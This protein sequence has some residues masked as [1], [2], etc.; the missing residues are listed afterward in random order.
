[1]SSPSNDINAPKAKG[2]S[3]RKVWFGASAIVLL[4][5]VLIIGKFSGLIEPLELAQAV[6][7][8]IRRF[9]ATPWGP[10]ALILTF[11][12]AA[13]IAIPQF[14]LIGVSVYAFGPI[15]GALWAWVATLCSGSLNYGVGRYFGAG[16]MERFAGQRVKA[17]SAFIARKTFVASAVVRNAPA[18]P[19]LFVN[20]LFGA[21]QASFLRY[22]SGMAAGIFPKIILVTF[23]YQAVI[24]VLA[25][26]ILF[27]VLAGG[28]ALAVFLGGWFYVRYK[29]RKGEIVALDGD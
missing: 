9:A 15:A 13:F 6:Q 14:V 7:V 19:F 26:N 1:M 2:G 4:I 20:M 8:E 22:I 27:A 12:V 24:A 25:G 23:G 17:F 29:R 11:C 3:N 18:G 5:I 10:A 28:A 21:V 16:L